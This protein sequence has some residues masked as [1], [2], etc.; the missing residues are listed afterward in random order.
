MHPCRFIRFRH[1]TVL[2]T[3]ATVPTESI[4]FQNLEFNC[5]EFVSLTSAH[6]PRISNTYLH[7]HGNGNKSRNDWDCTARN[8][9]CVCWRGMWRWEV[10]WGSVMYDVWWQV[11]L[12]C[13]AST[14]AI[15]GQHSESDVV[16]W[17]KVNVN[18]A[19]STAAQCPT[20]HACPWPRTIQQ[21]TT[22]T[23]M[24]I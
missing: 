21:L 8:N 18:G 2:L 3:V 20:H 23:G 11:A 1:L 12:S 9:N 13:A 14:S 10:E 15:Q 16:S 6:E 24:S 17:V 22:T 4:G 5:W 7:V 19:C